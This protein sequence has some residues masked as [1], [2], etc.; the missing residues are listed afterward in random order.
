[1][2]AVVEAVTGQPFEDVLQERVLDPLRLRNTGHD[3][4]ETILP[5]RAR[6]YAWGTRGLQNATYI[7]MDLPIGGGELY[8]TVDDLLAWVRV[9]ERCPLLK[10]ASREALFAPKL[11]KDPRTQK[12]VQTIAGVD[13]SEGGYAFGWFVGK[14]HDRPCRQH[15]GAIN[16]FT[17]YLAHFPEDDATVVVLCNSEIYFSVLKMGID[18]AAILYGEEYEL[19]VRRQVTIDLET[20]ARY[21]G[22]YEARPGVSIFITLENGQLSA[23]FPGIETQ[24]IYPSSETEFF[25]KT[26]TYRITFAPDEKGAVT[27]LTFHID[28]EREVPAKKVN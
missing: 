1:L 12:S 25:F 13:V 19:P 9:L 4:H 27:H 3:Q 20:L 21:R 26:S 2:A 5:H 8:S 14:Q 11:I 6:G 23:R 16:G 7:N 24:P 22:E 17:A 10:E 15:G 28:E 18:L